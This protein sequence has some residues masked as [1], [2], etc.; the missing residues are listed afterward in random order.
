[1]ASRW[2]FTKPQTR[3]DWI[4]YGAIVIVAIMVGI[5]AFLFFPG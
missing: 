1:M 3:E 4:I 5:A 2:R